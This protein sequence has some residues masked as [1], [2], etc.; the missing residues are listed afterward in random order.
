MLKVSHDNC[1]YCKYPKSFNCL[2]GLVFIIK[3]I[4]AVAFNTISAHEIVFIH[5]I[6]CDCIGSG[7]VADTLKCQLIK[8]HFPRY[9]FLIKFLYS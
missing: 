7:V 2:I 8:W 4:S 6:V 3:E 1:W 9:P 5:M